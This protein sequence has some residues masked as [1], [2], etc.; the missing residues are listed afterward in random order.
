MEADCGAV[1]TVAPRGEHAQEKLDRVLHGGVRGGVQPPA[2]LLG[3]LLSPAAPHG[4]QLQE[5]TGHT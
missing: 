2:V 3:H 5:A 1:H 4:G